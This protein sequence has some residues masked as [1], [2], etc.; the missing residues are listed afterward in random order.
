[1]F[2]KKTKNKMP[3]AKSKV[4]DRKRIKDNTVKAVKVTNVVQGNETVKRMQNGELIGVKTTT[5]QLEHAGRT[6]GNDPKLARNI[7]ISTY[8]RILSSSDFIE[9]DFIAVQASIIG[10]FNEDISN[11]IKYSERM[12]DFMWKQL[13]SNFNIMISGLVLEI[14]SVNSVKI[15][16]INT[17]LATQRT[18]KQPIT[19]EQFVNLAAEQGI[20]PSNNPTIQF[21]VTFFQELISS[22]QFGYIVNLHNVVLMR[23]DGG[24]KKDLA[25]I[26]SESF[27]R[28]SSQFIENKQMGNKK[29]FDIANEFNKKI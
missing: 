17:G 2:K 22:V 5:L 23:K 10:N 9:I 15:P 16:F 29:A 8:N 13:A 28:D 3:N 6:I 26:P 20:I 4:A 12:I 18:M 24:G 21:A 7:Y 14:I 27:F 1:M 25:F 11:L 19:V